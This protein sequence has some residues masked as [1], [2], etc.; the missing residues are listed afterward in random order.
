MIKIDKKEN[1]CGCTACYSICP[2]KAITMVEDSEGFKYPK[3]DK[4]KCIDCK[5]C[6]K[7]CPIL[8]KSKAKSIKEAKVIR[9][10]DKKILGQSTSGG[11]FTP[12]SEYIIKNGGYVFGALF[13][14]NKIMHKSINKTEE[15]EKFRG[16]K[17]VQS[18]LGNT[19]LEVKDLL[20]KD[21]YVLFSG[22]PCQINGL[23]S[24]LRRDY[25]KLYTVDVVCHGTPSPLLFR[26][27]VEY[28][29]RKYKS[30]I[31]K[32]N[33]RNKT[34]G[35]HVGTMKIEFEN[36]KTYYGSA[37]TDY[38]LKPFF[39]E[40]SSRPTCYECKFK[41]RDHISDFTIY[42]C[43]S[44]NKIN[45]QIKDDDKGYTN[46]IIN[47]KR[48]KELL[49]LIEEQYEIYDADFNK[50]VSLDGD[51]L[52]H[53]AHKNSK[54]NEFYDY[55]NENGIEKSISKYMPISKKDIILEKSKGLFH[56]LG[57]IKTLRKIRQ[58]ISKIK[59]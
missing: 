24:F 2:K 9:T 8:N 41:T 49:K 28:I 26:K 3:V 34:Y 35:Y 46:L 31:K 32:I 30:K 56:K 15:L 18:D 22:T 21:K 4:S 12:I 20:D 57:I 48:G 7:V 43:W 13:K 38:M 14:E 58:K 29:E 44:A 5:L 17:Y 59:K 36:G 52:E 23:K 16:S 55:L 47:T 40:I 54:R 1:C 19:F 53:V 39:K 51:M 11:F 50:A 25:D 10:K 37:R 33:F 6:E 45:N 42:D 27:Y